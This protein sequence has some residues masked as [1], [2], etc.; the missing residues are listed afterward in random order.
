M[1][2]PVLPSGGVVTTSTAVGP[3]LLLLGLCVRRGALW[4]ATGAALM[5]AGDLLFY[6]RAFLHGAPVL[7]TS[8]DVLFLLGYLALLRAAWRCAGPRARTVLLDALIV[9]AGPATVMAS[10][11]A[12]P[13]TAGGPTLKTAITL[14]Y[15]LLDL[16]LLVAVVTAALCGTLTRGQSWA[17]QAACVL[18][19]AGNTV[20]VVLLAWE[21]DVL[22]PWL[23]SVFSLAYALAALAVALEP[24]G[25]RDRQAGPGGREHRDRSRAVLV[26]LPAAS[27]LPAAALVTQGLL[28]HPVDW[29]VLGT[30]ALLTAVLSTLRLHGA[31]RTAAAHATALQRLALVD[32]LTGLPNR[33]SCADDLDRALQQPGRAGRETAVALLDLDRFK[34]VNDTLGH[35]AG[36]AL[37]REAAVAWRAA[38]PSGAGLYR[39]GGEEFVVLLRDVSALQALSVL[40]G[41]RRATPPPHTVSAGLAVPHPREAAAAVLARADA[42]LYTAKQSGRDRVCA[43]DPAGQRAD[44]APALA[45]VRPASG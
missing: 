5:I 41:V 43:S 11:V 25:P 18:L 8:A 32:D 10:V 20:F 17:L 24:G 44:A 3:V 28:G 30:G 29:R 4:G 12:A 36:D 7:V 38:L 19:L 31:L 14:A 1:A 9:V 27:C 26:L 22:T 23:V 16:A 15:P 40:D 13:L 39:W 33:R 21:P 45:P 2:S 35:A 42:A 6:A 37:L 34:T